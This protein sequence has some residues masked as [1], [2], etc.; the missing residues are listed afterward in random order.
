VRNKC[1]S[2]G[3][4]VKYTGSDSKLSRANLRSLVRLSNYLDS[5]GLTKEADYLDNI[6]KKT[7]ITFSPESD[8]GKHTSYKQSISDAI[9]DT[10][11][12]EYDQSLD[13][14]LS[15]SDGIHYDF[16]RHGGNNPEDLYDAMNY[17]KENN[18]AEYEKMFGQLSNTRS[19]YIRKLNEHIDYFANTYGDTVDW[20]DIISIEDSGSAIMD[21]SLVEMKEAAE[22][23]RSFY[24][25]NVHT[26]FNEILKVAKDIQYKKNSNKLIQMEVASIAN[27]SCRYYRDNFNLYILESGFDSYIKDPDALIM[28]IS[29]VLNKGSYHAPH[30]FT[31]DQMAELKKHKNLYDFIYKT[32]YG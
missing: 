3:F 11:F 20:N 4:D 10:A 26:L 24:N 17:I 14:G 28:A 7:A 12:P 18:L 15:I 30:E 29:C 8:I 13:S 9:I 23:L 6:I 27:R 5:K 25:N 32:I 16:L 21:K 2:D 31:D 1:K 22:D 19:D